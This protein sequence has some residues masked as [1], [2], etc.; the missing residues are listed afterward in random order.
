[1][2]THED[3]TTSPPNR[4]SLPEG[5]IVVSANTAATFVRVGTG[6]G[7]RWQLLRLTPSEPQ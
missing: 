7:A 3:L 5:S 1:M 6:D 4:F 2:I